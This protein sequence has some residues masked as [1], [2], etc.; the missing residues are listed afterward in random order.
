MED[1]LLRMTD[2]V[3]GFKRYLVRLSMMKGQNLCLPSIY[4]YDENNKFRIQI[5]TCKC[6]KKKVKQWRASCLTNCTNEQVSNFMVKK[7][8]QE[9]YL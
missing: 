8:E 2:L 6:C 1:I 3:V 5:D 7:K 9:T 4:L